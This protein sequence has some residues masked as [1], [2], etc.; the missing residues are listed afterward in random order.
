MK[1]H[2]M[3][4]GA[5]GKWRAYCGA[6]LFGGPEPTAKQKAKPVTCQRC[7]DKAIKAFHKEH[8]K[9]IEELEAISSLAQLA[10][11]PED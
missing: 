1:T 4:R 8:A 6:Y 2:Y 10:D 5:P 3:V 9:M 11:A 7:I